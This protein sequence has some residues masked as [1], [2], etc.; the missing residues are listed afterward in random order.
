MDYEFKFKIIFTLVG[1]VVLAVL[2]GVAWARMRMADR[3]NDSERE[4]E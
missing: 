4:R 2:G 1:W 3:A